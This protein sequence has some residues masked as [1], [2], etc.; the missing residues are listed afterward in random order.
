MRFGR[1]AR[2]DSRFERM[3]PGRGHEQ[4]RSSE[5]PARAAHADPQ[6]HGAPRRSTGR[7]SPKDAPDV[8]VFASTAAVGADLRAVVLEAHAGDD[9]VAHEVPEAPP[10]WSALR[11][12]A[13][14]GGRSAPSSGG[15]G[16]PARARTWRGDCSRSPSR[17]CRCTSVAAIAG[18]YV[19]TT[20]MRSRKVSATILGRPRP[21]GAARWST[22]ISSRVGTV[23][24]SRRSTERSEKAHFAAIMAWGG[25]R[26]SGRNP[27][28]S[29]NL[30]AGIAGP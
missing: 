22:A 16:A 28:E 19:A 11:G 25:E 12:Q 17:E 6:D 14:R 21:R 30:P 18:S 13:L 23:S 1:R 27:P 26:A 5:A 9:V 24:A 15:A 7:A 8:L 4:P 3:L 10:H 20:R 29:L 2:R